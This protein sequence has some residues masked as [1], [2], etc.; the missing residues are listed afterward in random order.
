MNRRCFERVNQILKYEGFR[1]AFLSDD[2][3]GP[4]VWLHGRAGKTIVPVNEDALMLMAVIRR[5]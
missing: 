1:E 4:Q 3:R 2:W 5:E